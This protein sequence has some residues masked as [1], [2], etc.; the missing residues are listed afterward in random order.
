MLLADAM[1][2]AVID[3]WKTDFDGYPP[4]VT[5]S[6]ITSSMEKPTLATTI[7]ARGKFEN[8]DMDGWDREIEPGDTFRFNVDSATTVK[9]LHLALS[10]HKD[11]KT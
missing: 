10:L 5:N 11:P 1:G 3:I 9:R 6:I 7:K 2:S 4:T 8:G